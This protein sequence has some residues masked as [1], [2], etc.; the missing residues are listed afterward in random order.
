M[1]GMLFSKRYA[2]KVDRF[3][4][5]S[6]ILWA[7]IHHDCSTAL[8]HVA[9][10]LTGISYRDEILQHHVIPHLN[11]NGVSQEFLQRHNVQTLPWS[12]CSPD[13]NPTEHLWYALHQRMSPRNPP[14]QILAYRWQNITQR[15]MQ[16]LIVSIHRGSCW[17]QPILTFYPPLCHTYACYST[18]P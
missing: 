11:V 2:Q 1:R 12:A 4:G 7:G 18:L 9:V 13:L 6:V 8:V 10:T 16:H 14:P 5:G 17:S 15:D 3:C